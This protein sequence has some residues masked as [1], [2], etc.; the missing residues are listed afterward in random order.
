MTWAQGSC[1]AQGDRAVGLVLYSETCHC[2]GDWR[3]E[4]T[5]RV[6]MPPIHKHPEHS[7]MPSPCVAQLNDKHFLETEP[8]HTWAPASLLSSRFLDRPVPAWSQLSC[9]LWVARPDKYQGPEP[10]GGTISASSEPLTKIAWTLM[11]LTYGDA[12]VL[13]GARY[14]ILFCPHREFVQGPKFKA[15]HGNTGICCALGLSF[16]TITYPLDPVGAVLEVRALRSL[17]AQGDGA[18][19]LSLHIQV[20][21]GVGV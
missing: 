4:W 10:G 11:P 3:E 7:Y 16:V 17:P 21:D 13:P 9:R 12:E 1:L 20:P 19:G 15:L 6:S 2:L 14:P 18:G 8:R 5:V